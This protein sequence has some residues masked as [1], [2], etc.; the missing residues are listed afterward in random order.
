MWQLASACG[1]ISWAAAAQ[2][3]LRPSLQKPELSSACTSKLYPLKAGAAV[4]L[5]SECIPSHCLP[6]KQLHDGIATSSC[7]TPTA[8]PEDCS[9]G[10]AQGAQATVCHQLAA[11]T[12]NYALHQV[13]HTATPAGWAWTGAPATVRVARPA[14]APSCRRV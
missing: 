2:P 13:P 11:T 6:S 14:P 10:G 3:D 12:L 1:R 9:V 8:C 5:W 7:S 4:N